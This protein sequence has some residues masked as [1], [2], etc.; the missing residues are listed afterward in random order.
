MLGL[1]HPQ[2][3]RS[4]ANLGFVFNNLGKCDE[5]ERLHRYA[6]DGLEKALG[7]EHAV[8]RVVRKDLAMALRAKATGQVRV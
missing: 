6:L 2:T 1:E 4:M 3:L 7:R 5:A 8:T